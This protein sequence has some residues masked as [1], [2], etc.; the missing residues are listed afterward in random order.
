MLFV[1]EILDYT[2]VN[3]RLNATR[4]LI[5]DQ[6][7]SELSSEAFPQRGAISLAPGFSPVIRNRVLKLKPFQRFLLRFTGKPLETVIGIIVDL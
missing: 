2:T 4:K 1:R 7:R 5:A 6:S 3:T